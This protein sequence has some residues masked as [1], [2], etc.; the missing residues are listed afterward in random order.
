[1]GIQQTPTHLINMGMANKIA[2]FMTLQFLFTRFKRPSTNSDRCTIS[3]DIYE[4]DAAT[5]EA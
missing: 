4:A 3:S 2:I 1:M 5:L